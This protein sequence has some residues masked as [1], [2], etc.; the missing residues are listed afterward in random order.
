MIKKLINDSNV[1]VCSSAIKIAGL[2]ANGLRKSLARHA[3]ILLTPLYLKLKDKKGPVCDEA[4]KA[5]KLYLHCVKIEVL[6]EEIK[7]CLSDK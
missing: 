5:L 1:S 2:L 6:L 4:L 3:K 7:V